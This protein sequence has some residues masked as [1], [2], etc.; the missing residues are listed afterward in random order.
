MDDL[1]NLLGLDG[2]SATNSV[3][4]SPAPFAVRRT[5]G[6]ER[7]AGALPSDAPDDERFRQARSVVQRQATQLFYEAWLPRLLDELTRGESPPEELLALVLQMLLWDETRAGRTEVIDQQ[8]VFPETGR[9][10]GTRD[11]GGR[12]PKRYRLDFVLTQGPHAKVA[13]EC[14]GYNFHRRTRREFAE[15]LRRE[16]EVQKLGYRLYRFAADDLFDDPWAAGLEIVRNMGTVW[17]EFEPVELPEEVLAILG[18]SEPGASGATPPRQE[19]TPEA[20]PE[21]DASDDAAGLTAGE[22]ARMVR[23]LPLTNAPS[24]PRREEIRRE[25]RRAWEPWTEQEDAWL[26]ELVASSGETATPDGSSPPSALPTL[27]SVFE[28]RP[29]AIHSRLVKLGLMDR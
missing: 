14:D 3:A 21:K 5:P 4:E 28:R 22:I 17:P 26:R 7:P 25:H 23:R 20:D 10:R 29:S 24:N 12:A 8:E 9:T 1:K 15:E 2:R 11:G 16:R 13:I 19:R 18:A 27:A 6:R